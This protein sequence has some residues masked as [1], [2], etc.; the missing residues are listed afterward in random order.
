V[1]VISFTG[2]S[3]VPPELETRVGHLLSRTLAEQWFTDGDREV[4]GI[5]GGASGVDTIAAEILYYL[6]FP[7]VLALPD[8]DYK[9][10][11]ID[12]P[13]GEKLGNSRREWSKRFDI[14]ADR[15]EKVV[16]VNES[17]RPGNNFRRN[18]WMVDHSDCTIAVRWRKSGGTDHCIKYVKF[19]QK[20]REHPLVVLNPKED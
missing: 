20:Q 18:E 8:P 4:R 17:K 10:Y 2:H 13:G 5:V 14:V 16:F 3:V 19:V 11:W 7:Y 1:K 15:A 12:G 6:K 9:A